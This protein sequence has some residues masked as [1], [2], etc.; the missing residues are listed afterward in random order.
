M[1]RL[2]PSWKRAALNL[3]AMR[4]AA[5]RRLPKPVFDYADG[6]AEDEI[7]L[8]RNET[9]FSHF[10]LRP[11]PLRGAGTRDLS[12]EL[13]GRRLALPILLGPTG[14]AGLFWPEGEKEAA[15][16]AAAAGT[17]F[18][19]SHGSVCALEALD[20]PGMPRRWM[21]VFIYRDRGFTYS[22]AD[23]AAASGYE[24]LVLTIDNQFLGKCERD[25]RNGFAI[26]PRFSLRDK[27]SALTR[28][29]WIWRMRRQLPNLTFG[30]Y[31]TPGA[32][33]DIATL[34]GR[35]QSL[36]D[37]DMTWRDVAELRR[38]WQKP[39]LLKG[40]L[41][42]ADAAEAIAHGVDGLIVSN[43]GGRQ[44]DGAVSSIEALPDVVAA[45]GGRIPVLLDGGVRRG[46]D[47]IRALA[48]GATACTVGRPTLWGLTIAGGEGVAHM[49]AVFR[50][51]IDRAMGLCGLQTLAEIGSD[52]IVR[53]GC[54]TSR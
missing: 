47:V 46:T 48:L 43:H 5:R 3:A 34:A 4:E 37:P 10:A 25:R 41:H 29:R 26:P 12:V 31:V 7:T 50:D 15:R 53:R 39:L 38:R 9:A 27:L 33:A 24:A 52:L 42:P 2:E 18:C 16:A 40:I 19:L 36:L 14:L 28:L 44:L 23:R 45:V 35:M 49:L 22:L 13:Y 32:T 21:Q 8:R 11:R 6:G 51:E 17:V 30:N 1:S 20:A 54:Q